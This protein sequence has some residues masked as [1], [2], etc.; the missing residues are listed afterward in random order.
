LPEALAR[1]PRGPILTAPVRDAPPKKR[2]ATLAAKIW[3]R[4]RPRTAS[5]Y[6]SLVVAAVMIGVAVNALLLQRVRHPA[7]FFASE[8]LP[9]PPAAA[10]PAPPIPPVPPAKTPSEA[11]LATPPPH[12]FAP[13]LSISPPMRA[14]DPIGDLVRANN[15]KESSKT[16]A[17]VQAA[18]IRLGYVVKADGAMGGDSEEAIRDFEK[19]HN[20]PIST[21]L[22]PRLL[23]KLGVIAR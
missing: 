6:L 17:A 1:A 2:K 21:E 11:N 12:P 18:L 14:N 16:I 23:A 4:L 7:P 8:P 20:L 5:G 9:A 3:S 15:A 10:P 19:N 13:S 22:S